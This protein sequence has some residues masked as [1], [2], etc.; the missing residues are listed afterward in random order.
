MPTVEQRGHAR[1]RYPVANR[2][3]LL[4]NN[5]ALDLLD[6]SETGLRY[7]ES[8]A[9]P[10]AILGGDIR[11]VV[12]LRNGQKVAVAGTVV[13]VSHDEVAVLLDKAGIPLQTIEAEQSHL[14]RWRTGLLW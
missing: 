6:L 11:G 2:S 13:R 4:M 12:W 10:R 7:R 14:S 1:L 8:E 3:G 9:P 5:Q